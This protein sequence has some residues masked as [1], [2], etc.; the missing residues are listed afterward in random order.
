MGVNIDV[1]AKNETAT[2]QINVLKLQGLFNKSLENPKDG[3]CS[4]ENNLV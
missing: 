3:D 1:N 2:P 4:I